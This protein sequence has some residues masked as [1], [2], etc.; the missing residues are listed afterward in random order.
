MSSI[1]TAIR[2]NWIRST[3]PSNSRLLAVLNSRLDLGEAEAIVLAID[4][5]A[6][7]VLIDEQEGR[8]FAAQAGLKVTGVLGI[9]LRA[10][11][12]GAIPALRPAIQLLR[13]KARFF[14]SSS[15]EARILA[16]AGE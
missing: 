7:I 6:D 14:I 1:Q 9:L 4:V 3:P 16:S 15:L 10:K 2:N 11:L 12:M 13:S 8:Q 5:K